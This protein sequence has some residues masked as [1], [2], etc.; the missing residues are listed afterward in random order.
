MLHERDVKGIVVA[1][2]WTVVQSRGR[3]TRCRWLARPRRASER[4]AV[5]S[6]RSPR[7]RLPFAVTTGGPLRPPNRIAWSRARRLR[8]GGAVLLS[9]RA[10]RQL[11]ALTQAI[12]YHVTKAT[13]V[14]YWHS[15]GAAAGTL[16]LIHI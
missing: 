16:S 8:E 12:S 6:R 3:L 1:G 14:P 4:Q 11:L 13:L 10:D 9:H 7:D 15:P 2:R 5:A